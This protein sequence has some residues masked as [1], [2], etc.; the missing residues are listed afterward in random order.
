[1]KTKEKKFILLELQEIADSE[2]NE[3]IGG[4]FPPAPPVFKN[5]IDMIEDLLKIPYP[6]EY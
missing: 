2:R 1:M 4:C 3:I 6:I 5:P